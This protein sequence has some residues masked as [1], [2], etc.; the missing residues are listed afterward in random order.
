MN[1]S[2]D[3]EKAS[4]VSACSAC[5][6]LNTLPSLLGLPAD[7]R[8]ARLQEVIFNAIFAFFEA[9]ERHWGLPLEPSVN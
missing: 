9:T 1:H 4:D 8:Y 2:F 7:E 3:D 6:L 5:L